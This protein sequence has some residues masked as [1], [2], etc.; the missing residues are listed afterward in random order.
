MKNKRLPRTFFHRKTIRVAKELLGKYLVVKD[1]AYGQ[2]LVG[3]I[4][5]TEAYCGQND[6]A[7]HAHYR[8]RQSCEVLWGEAGH[9][10]VYLTYGMHWM[11]NV[12]TE[13]KDY[14]SAVLIRAIEPVDGVLVMIQNRNHASRS[15]NNVGLTSGPAKLTQALSING[16]FN[17]EDLENSKR[18]WVEDRGVKYPRSKVCRSPRIGVDYAGQYKDKPWRFF[19]KGSPFVSKAKGK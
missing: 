11:L 13:R 6:E 2:A 3:K 8:K 4:V 18:I 19:V 10:Y 5:E 1:T 16:S 12:V 14:P 17:G 9:L 15:V 7:C